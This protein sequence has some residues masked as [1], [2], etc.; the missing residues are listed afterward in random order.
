[1]EEKISVLMPAYNRAS[2]IRSAITSILA[3]TYR[4]LE[5]IVYDDG[6]RDGTR[7][8]VRGFMSRDARVRLVEGETNRGVAFARNRLLE[9]TNSKYACWQ[10]SDDI[11]NIHR[12]EMQ[13]VKMKATGNILVFSQYEM[14]MGKKFTI[15]IIGQRRWMRPP[16]IGKHINRGFATVMF[17][18]AIAVP[19]DETKK[20][21]GED[22]A[23]I[24]EIEKTHS[25]FPV[26]EETLYYI[27]GHA[28]R[29]GAWKRKLARIRGTEI[30]ARLSYEELIRNYGK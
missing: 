20:L 13:I 26:M 21:G 1:M 24:N 14:L 25:D 19:F 27:Y 5:L 8:M 22:W 15:G 23:W 17:E 16:A 6:S 2:F 9:A 28:D 11:S 29:I 18:T 7:E 4:K 30:E 10:D 12:L 3:Q